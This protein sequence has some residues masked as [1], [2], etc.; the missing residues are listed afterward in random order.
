MV[1]KLGLLIA[2]AISIASI[3]IAQATV[4]SPENLSDVTVTPGYIASWYV[5]GGDLPGNQSPSTIDSWLSSKLGLPT[6]TTVSSCDSCTVVNNGTTF[7]S[8]PADV[9]AIHFGQN[10]L[11]FEY[12][13]NIT[14]F[15]INL[16]QEQ[17]LSNVRSFEVPTATPLPA[18][19]PMFL[20]GLGMVGFL[21]RRRKRQVAV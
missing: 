3:G 2:G 18:A 8:S 19:L 13:S 16:G 9:F 15:S 4:V 7:A 1:G 21:A 12:G 6:A 5:T 11:V 14:S 10:E 17:G 20:G